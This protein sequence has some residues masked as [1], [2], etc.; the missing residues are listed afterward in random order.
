M[1]NVLLLLVG[2]AIGNL[3]FAGDANPSIETIKAWWGRT[4]N[5]EISITD[6][7][8]P[9]PITLR[10]HEPAYLRGVSFFDRGRNFMDQTLL[11]R[12]KLR[13][14]REAGDLVGRDSVVHDLDHDGISEIETVSLG[15]GQGTTMGTRSLVQFDGWTPVVLH[16]AKFEDDEGVWGI[17]DDRYY[18]REVD[19]KFR[20]L[21]GD[22][23]DDL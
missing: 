6:D 20:D 21:D 12:P 1:R 14:V 13:E 15:S 5:E 7:R 4:S 8:G 16:Q 23:I 11:I 17:R 9:L 3:S 2:L 10:N 22:G 18:A 19:W